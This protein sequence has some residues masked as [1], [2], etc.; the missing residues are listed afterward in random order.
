MNSLKR[1]ITAELNSIM[2]TDV[3][4]EAP[5]N[6]EFGDYATPA[7]IQD[8]NE[9]GENPHEYAAEVVDQLPT[10]EWDF[11]QSVDVA[12]QGYINFH[13]HREVLGEAVLNQIDDPDINDKD[14]KV[15]V[16]HT[17]PNPNKPLHMGTMRCAILGD[18]ISRVAEYL[19]YDV[20]VQ[21]YINDLG[22]QSATAIYAYKNFY[23]SLSEDEKERKADYWIGVLYAKAA[24][25][26]EENEEADEEVEEIIRDIEE[27]DNENHE[28][29]QEVVEKSLRGQ[30]D[31]AHRTSIYY[32]LIEFEGDVVRSGLFKEAVDK[33]R[34]VD[35]VYEITEGE[36]EGCIVIDMQDYEE[37]LGEMKKPYKILIRSDG[38][39]TYT[40]KDIALTLWKF[41]VIDSEFQYRK[42]D[43]RPDGEDYWATGGDQDLVFGNA[44]SVINVIGRPQKFPMQVVESAL[45]ALDFE[46]QADNFNHL[47]FKFVYLTGDALSEETTADKVAYSGRKG[48]W[49]GKHGDAVLDQTNDLA[50]EEIQTRYPEKDSEAAERIAEKVSVA[51]VRYFLLRFSR[52]KEIDFS[53]SKVLDWSGDS[54]PYMLYSVARAHGI[55]EGL[56]VEPDCIELSE[57]AEIEL[58]HQLDEFHEVVQHTYE[59]QEPSK[60][61]HYLRSL[62]EVFNTFY[63]KCSVKDAETEA[64]KKSRAALTWGFITVME[65]GLDLLGIE[66]VEQL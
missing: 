34:D 26:L 18:S 11:L 29:M 10:E 46:E 42:F 25:Y 62:A 52:K 28:L 23:D 65:E 20:E 24:Q 61:C 7:A 59:I 35:K 50:L 39:A 64:V 41:G 36:D 21:N 49:M 53:F 57:E 8:A 31:T 37:E 22:R 14:K 40:A 54:G 16:E 43:T 2:D 27:G 30:I 1:E 15:V 63:H 45:R 13:L 17:S 51:A 60:L 19:G 38:T 58:L 55:L 47:D 4:L 48:N 66:T 3:S 9:R 6:T 5:N 32:D 44:D 56:D 33:L 12:G